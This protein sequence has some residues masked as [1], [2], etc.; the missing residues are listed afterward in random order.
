MCF[1][2]IRSTG[3]HIVLFSIPS[4]KVSYIGLGLKL[5]SKGGMFAVL[6]GNTP[7]LPSGKEC[8]PPPSFHFI[9][10]TCRMMRIAQF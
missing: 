4:M 1:R 10:Y 8:V 2:K 5:K 3:M 9:F 6:V 7:P